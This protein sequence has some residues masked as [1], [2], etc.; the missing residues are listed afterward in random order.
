[1]C[2]TDTEETYLSRA[3]AAERLGVHPDTLRAW[4]RKNQIP[5]YRVGGVARYLLSD[6]L[7]MVQPANKAARER[8]AP[9]GA[10]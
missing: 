4:G 8:V 2:M 6:V 1:M 10:V 3:E 9:S 7:A 5:E